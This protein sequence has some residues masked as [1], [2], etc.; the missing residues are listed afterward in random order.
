MS[1]TNRTYIDFEDF[2]KSHYQN[3]YRY[4]R[5][6]IRNNNTAVEDVVQEVFFIAYE[7]WDIVAKHPNIPGFLVVVARNRIRKWFDKQSKFSVNEESVLEFLDKEESDSSGQ[8][9]EADPFSMVEL[10]SAMEKVL[11]HEEI[12]ILRHYYEYGYTSAEM[13]RILGITESCFKVRVL[14]MKEKLKKGLKGLSLLAA[15]L[16]AFAL[17]NIL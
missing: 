8:N 17:W 11:T 5:R 3:V 1:G 15:F 4:V 10:Y 14:R 16:P 13:A 9:E 2:Y 6:V 7:K 12:D